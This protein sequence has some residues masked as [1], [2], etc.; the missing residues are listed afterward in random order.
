[1][2]PLLGIGGDARR[3]ILVDPVKYPVSTPLD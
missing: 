3:Q 2:E 1:M